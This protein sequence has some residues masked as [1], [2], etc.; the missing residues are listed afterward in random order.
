MQYG[1]KVFL[2]I[3]FLMIF[4][5][6]GFLCNKL[7]KM[8]RKKKDIK[9]VSFIY[10]VNIVFAVL[11][12]YVLRHSV[13]VLYTASRLYHLD[14]SYSEVMHLVYWFNGCICFA[15]LCAVGF[16]KV[17]KVRKD[18][19]QKN[20]RIIFLWCTIMA[21]V[22]FIGYAFQN[23]GK[24]VLIINEVAA[25]NSNIY[26][27]EYDSYCD[28]I[29]F[30]NKG[31][32]ICELDDLYVSDDKENLKKI[33]LSGGKVNPGGFVVLGLDKEKS[34]YYIER[35]GQSRWYPPE[36][37]N[38]ENLKKMFSVS[39]EGEYIYLSDALGNII[40]SVYT[41]N[42]EENVVICRI[43]DG[44]EVWEMRRGTPGES[45]SQADLLQKIS[46]PVLSHY[47][48]FYKDEFELSI[49][50]PK[51]AR[52]Y[53]TLDGSTPDENSTEYKEPVLVYD[54]SPEENKWRNIPNVVTKWK[55]AAI[56]QTP[57]VDKAF[58]LKA[59]AM[60]EDG[61]KSDI[62]QATYFVNKPEYRKKNIVSI[63]ADPEAL[64]GQD[65]IYVTGKEYDDWY[66]A[67]GAE[68]GEE[69]PTVNFEKR[70]RK[71]EIPAMIEL[72]EED[73]S[74]VETIG[75]KVQGGGSRYEAVKRFAAIARKEYGGS[76]WFQNS[77]F[78][79]VRTHAVNFRPG[80]ANAVLPYL[81]EDRNVVT[82]Q[83]VPVDIFLNGE[84]WY[85]GY[86]QER[87]TNSFLEEKY[88]LEEDSVYIV[89]D[90][91]DN[92]AFADSMGMQEI[93]DYVSSHD[94]SQE[95]SYETFC[96]MVDIDSYVDFL[97]INM[98]F[99][100]MD[101][102]ENKNFIAWKEIPDG[103]WKFAIY[104]LDSVDPEV[105]YASNYYTGIE[106]WAQINPFTQKGEFVDRSL[107]E[108][109][110]YPAL[111]NNADF[112]RKMVLT[113]MDLMNDNFSV[114]NVERVL[115]EWG[116]DITWNDSFFLKRADYMCEYIEEEFGL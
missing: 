61:A 76:K 84:Y 26:M 5:V 93:Y 11:L 59:I 115:E 21:L 32:L 97:C 73:G 56:D 47:S 35:N 114:S 49:T 19:I 58:I 66:L 82:Q 13:N 69:R 42:Q 45:N 99:A 109:R 17:K 111:Y 44:K 28:Y 39:E 71:S 68:T 83:S 16:N 29:E 46:E 6:P 103:K 55:E 33:K 63:T 2:L 110:L 10:L 64:F 38:E 98:Y 80:F 24:M 9:F 70:G 3:W 18:T 65:G 41:K 85:S 60:D 15:I 88:G 50:G 104:D 102:E 113:F 79:N 51:N 4:I 94:M 37:L 40:D 27:D 8:E 86:V 95:E 108:N 78:E 90:S 22:G 34:V 52:I 12:H 116:E 31:N 105:F 87:V 96:E 23:Q 48:G 20:N 101:W 77:W 106:E 112:R 7:V 14:W 81:V 67:G 92:E 100:H 53:Y 72:I 91:R 54:K 62:V 107:K 57:P 25:N 75:L 36:E 30:Y 1:L 89:E 74:K 43:E